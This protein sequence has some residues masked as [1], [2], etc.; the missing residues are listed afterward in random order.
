MDGG[1][2]SVSLYTACFQFALAPTDVQGNNADPAK[3]ADITSNSWGC[4]AA[5]QEPGCEIGTALITVTQALRDAGIIVVAS[6]GNSGS[7]CET[8]MNAPAMLNQAFSVGAVGTTNAIA[9]FSSRG[10]SRLTGRLKPDLV[11]PGV[12]VISAYRT[13]TATYTSLSGTSMAAPHVAGVVALL[14]SGAPWLRGQVDLTEHILRTTA[15]PIT[16]TQSCGSAQAG[17]LPN[18]TYGYGLIN[19]EAALNY[20]LKNRYRYYYPLFTK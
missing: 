13:T 14:W 20:A 1:Y 19:A 16:T 12:G 9:G 2:G 5:A 15:T 6:A 10:P 17:A 4:D 11:A 8:V 3:A 18:N 7:A